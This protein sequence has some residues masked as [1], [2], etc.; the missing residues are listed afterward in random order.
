LLPGFFYG[1]AGIK[2]AGSW[3]GIGGGM[4]GN[5][6]YHIMPMSSRPHVR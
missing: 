2:G 5:R 3:C 1:L 4:G 6:G